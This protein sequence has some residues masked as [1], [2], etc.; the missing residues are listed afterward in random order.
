MR[1]EAATLAIQDFDFSV[2]VLRVMLWQYN[3]ADNLKEILQK[4]AKFYQEKQH[5]FW[6]KWLVDVFDLRTA[7][8]FGLSVWTTILG[9]PIPYYEEEQDKHPTF[10]FEPPVTIDNRKN[11]SNGNFSTITK[12]FFILTREQKRTLLRMRFFQ[13]TTKATVTDINRVFTD[14]FPDNTLT[15]TDNLDMTISYVFLHRPSDN[16]LLA[17]EQFDVVPRPSAVAINFHFLDIRSFGFGSFRL[18]FDRGNFYTG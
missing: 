7:N 4:K 8:D 18:N 14:F 15:V 2:D 9:V 3:Q 6:Q 12:S 10:G 13:L 16:L 1:T 11:F 17:M 5:D